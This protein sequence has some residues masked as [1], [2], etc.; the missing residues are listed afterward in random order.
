MLINVA[1]TI[2]QFQHCVLVIPRGLC[3]QPTA[4]YLCDRGLSSQ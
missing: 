1:R 4:Q 3:Q 2:S